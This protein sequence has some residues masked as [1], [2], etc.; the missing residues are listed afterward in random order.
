MAMMFG[1]ARRMLAP[2]STVVAGEI[3]VQRVIVARYHNAVT[4]R[5]RLGCFMRTVAVGLYRTGCQ[6]SPPS[7]VR[8]KRSGWSST[9]CTIRPCSASPCASALMETMPGR[10]W[11][12]QF[13]PPSVELWNSSE[14]AVAR[15]H[16]FL[17]VQVL[18]EGVAV[19]WFCSPRVPAVGCERP[20]RERADEEGIGLPPPTCW[21]PVE[22]RSGPVVLPGEPPS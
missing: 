7:V 14:D 18:Q 5:R 17:R 8:N 11:S 20:A 2:G 15:A 19:K 9:T 21:R 10:S 16:H 1:S 6:V 12:T 3:D 22:G 13:A 4:I